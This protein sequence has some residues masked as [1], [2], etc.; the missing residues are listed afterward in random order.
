VERLLARVDRLCAVSPVVLVTEDLHWADEASVLVWSRLARAVWQVPLLLVGSYRPGSGREDLDRLRRRAVRD[1]NVLELGPLPDVRVAELVGALV[2]GRPGRQLAGVISRAGGNPLYAHE[3][4]DSLVRDGQVAVTG[5]VA[6]ITGVPAPVRVPDSLDAAIGERL[7]GMAE[8]AVQAL[9][10]ATVLGAEFSVTDLQ[11]VSGQSAGEL[12]GMIG[13]ALRAGVLA[14]AGTRLEFR[15]GLIRQVLY[16]G[17]PTA[18]RSALHLGAA[19]ALAAAGADA[20][21]VAAQLTA[22]QQAAGPDAELASDW[23]A[24]W[25][26]AEAPM[27]S[28]RAP[29]VA[30]ELFRGVLARLSQDDDRR[31]VLEAS[32][33]TV[34][35]LLMRLEEVERIGGRLAATARDPGRA[36]EMAWLVAYSRVR[37]GHIAEAGPLVEAALARPGTGQAA[38]RLMALRAMILELSNRFDE[39]ERA[40]GEA[41]TA[42]EKAGDRLAVGYVHHTLT[43]L[44]ATQRDSEAALDQTGRALAVIGDDPQATDLRVLVLANRISLLG[45]MDRW[46]EATAEAREALALAEQAG[47]PRVVNIRYA[48]GYQY[49][50]GGQWDDALAEFEPVAGMPMPDYLQILVYGLI[51]LI[52]AHRDDWQTAEDYL[53]RLQEEPASHTVALANVHYVLLARAMAAEQAGRPDEATRVL[54][55]ALNHH[56]LSETMQGRSLLLPPLVRLSLAAGDTAT[57]AKAAA[58]AREEADR[59]PLPFKVAIAGHCAGLVAGDTAA[60][61]ATARYYETT[62]QVLGQATA[63]EDAAALMAS[64]ADA[65]SARKALAA[66]LDV[67]QKLGAGWDVR[68]ADARLRQYGIRRARANSQRR[69]QTGWAALTPTETKVASLVA[70]GRSNPDIA[71]HLFLSRNTVQ[72]HVSHIL[73]KLGARSRAEITRVAM[74]HSLEEKW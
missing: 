74:Q 62:G 59:E 73:T 24:N 51:S 45:D 38:A 36:A 52:A 68:R 42:A 71:A 29:Q 56:G 28:Y 17:L 70:E 39:T 50:V 33:A 55:A 21:R 23:A 61:L 34:S 11:A 67:Y 40:A 69:P 19:R 3:L 4:A 46:A 72:T 30:A 44:R 18:L 32:L 35:F 2:G 47:T 63:L 54:A 60:V 48:L 31:E 53:R 1:E 58:A 65:A 25:L 10:W 57:A 9:R 43:L 6:E 8:D 27:L 64:Q 13:G 12:M 26:A 66:A 22:A 7:A 20:E 49:F 14:E 41:L 16:E 15:H 37:T 5:G